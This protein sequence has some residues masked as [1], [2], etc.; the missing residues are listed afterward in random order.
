MS[1]L[2]FIH[3]VYLFKILLQPY[4]IALSHISIRARDKI[5]ARSIKYAGPQKVRKSP[6]KE[7]LDP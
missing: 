7:G 5:S 6:N 1:L 2:K 4:Y 3:S